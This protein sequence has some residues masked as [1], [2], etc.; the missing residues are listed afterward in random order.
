M[1]KFYLLIPVVILITIYFVSCS[2]S[3]VTS[4]KAPTSFYEGYNDDE[5]AACMTLASLA[6]VNENNPAYMRDS[7]IVQLANN[8]YETGGN[9]KLEWGPALTPDKANMLYVVKD[10]LK[11]P[12]MYAIAIRGTDWCFLTNIKEDILVY[13]MVPYTYSGNVN[14][15]ISEG[16]SL[17]LSKILS[18]LDPLSHKTFLQYLT[19]IKRPIP[20]GKHDLFITGHSLGGALATVLTSWMLDN[21]MGH[22]FNIKSYTFA[23]PTVGNKGYVEHFNSI[24]NSAGAESHRVVNP[25]DIIPRFISEIDTI[26]LKQYPTLLPLSIETAFFAMYSYFTYE[27][28]YYHHVGEVRY[29][30]QAIPGN[31][32]S[33]SPSFDQYSCWVGFEHDHN[34]YLRLLNAPETNFYYAPCEMVQ[35]DT[36]GLSSF[37][38]THRK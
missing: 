34:T 37:I 38:K 31:C 32:P 6:Y 1:K 8:N 36:T 19:A 16:A 18:L 2:N 9:W 20:T 15:S 30:G 26:L 5:S 28:I 11:N 12:D 25:R 10:T 4:Q 33:G 14:D 24:V 21:G 3:P 17:G 35:P 13:S 7:L 29:L 27:G 22:V 23:A